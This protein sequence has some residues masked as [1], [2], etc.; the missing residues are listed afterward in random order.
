MPRQIL[1]LDEFR[2][3]QRDA[4][5]TRVDLDNGAVVWFQS[6]FFY[7]ED[8]YA[9]AEEGDPRRLLAATLGGEDQL[10]VFL[11]NGG[12][13]AAGMAL[14]YKHQ[15]LP[16][17]EA[18][19]SSTTSADGGTSSRPTSSGTTTSTSSTSAPPTSPFDGSAA[20]P[21]TSPASRPRT[22]RSTP[23]KPRGGSKPSS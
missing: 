2:T 6:P 12:T 4:A 5:A 17:G 9:A 19:A 23:T 15:G 11:A 14:L 7:S 1:S 10:E 3:E 20:S 16:V 21:A 8:Y 18:L 13:L 22:K